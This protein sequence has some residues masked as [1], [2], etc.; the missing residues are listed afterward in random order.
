MRRSA[1]ENEKALEAF[2]FEGF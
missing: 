2:R 1:T